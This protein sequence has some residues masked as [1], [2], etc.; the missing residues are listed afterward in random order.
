MANL[1]LQCT[2]SWSYILKGRQAWLSFFHNLWREKEQREESCLGAQCSQERHEFRVP[3]LLPHQQLYCAFIQPAT[4]FS[5]NC[6]C[7]GAQCSQ[8]R[9]EFR[10]PVLLPHQQLYSAFIQPAKH[11]TLNCTFFQER[12]LRIGKISLLF[13]L[14]W[15]ISD[16][17]VQYW[18][19]WSTL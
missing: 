16:L 19:T 3:V 17:Y 11:F 13:I 14:C 12:L 18:L 9:H 1:F 15:D 2:N 8:E 10:V 7:L 5:L 4:Q 6:S